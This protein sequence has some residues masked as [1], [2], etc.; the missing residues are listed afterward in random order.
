MISSKDVFNNVIDTSGLKKIQNI[1]LEK[2]QNFMEMLTGF[3]SPTLSSFSNSLENFSVNVLNVFKSNDNIEKVIAVHGNDLRE[4]QNR[5]IRYFGERSDSGSTRGTK[6]YMEISNEEIPYI[7]TCN[8]KYKEA[9]SRF[10]KISEILKKTKLYDL[11]GFSSLSNYVERLMNSEEE[12]TTK[13]PA[14]LTKIVDDIT[15]ANKEITKETD[16][17]FS[18]DVSGTIKV[19]KVIDSVRDYEESVAKAIY[20][21][22]TFNLGFINNLK[23]ECEKVDERVQYL[24]SYIGDGTIVLSEPVAKQL[25]AIIDAFANVVSL[26]ATVAAA[27]LEYLESII[28]LGRMFKDKM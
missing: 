8:L 18:G 13:F 25:V 15:F 2:D 1:K 4:I 24:A 11:K 20:L 21:T 27:F 14:E 17:M 19:A 16:S 26:I 23:R 9:G 28:V 12:R 5:V 6:A 10:E 22:K 7:T 3:I